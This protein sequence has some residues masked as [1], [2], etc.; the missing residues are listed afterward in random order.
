MSNCNEGADILNRIITISY[1][2]IQISV[3]LFISVVGAVH[4]RRCR[5]EEKIKMQA[6]ATIT[7]STG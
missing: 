5:N 1:A 2:S 6:N 3:A 7:L 4:V